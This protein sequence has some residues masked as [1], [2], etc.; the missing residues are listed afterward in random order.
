MLGTGGLQIA[1]VKSEADDPGYTLSDEKRLRPIAWQLREVACC[2]IRTSRINSKEVGKEH[3]RIGR[4]ALLHYCYVY[5]PSD[6]TSTS[7]WRVV[8]C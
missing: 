6:K 4:P 1:T 7:S 8:G 2:E 5:S 3:P